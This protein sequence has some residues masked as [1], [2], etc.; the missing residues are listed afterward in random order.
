[1]TSVSFIENLK[2]RKQIIKKLY[3][4]SLKIWFVL[5]PYIIIHITIHICS[6]SS[7]QPS[8]FVG[9]SFQ[10][11]RSKDVVLL[12][13][14]YTGSRKKRNP[15][16]MPYQWR[17]QPDNLVTLCKFFCLYRPCKESI[18]KEM[19]NDNDL[20]LHSMT[21]LSGWLRYCMCFITRIKR[22]S[23]PDLYFMISFSLIFCLYNEESLVYFRQIT[24]SAKEIYHK[25]SFWDAS[26]FV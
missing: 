15:T 21:K 11:R 17:S 2:M 22:S 19:N 7:W 18:S 20:N 14:L 13:C 5:L 23:N 3:K 1:M 10:T 8:L 16:L 4:I 9:Y 25:R 24:T 26:K 12:K 6:T